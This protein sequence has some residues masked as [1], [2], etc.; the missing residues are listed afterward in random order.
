MNIRCRR[1]RKFQKEEACEP[2][3]Y[4]INNFTLFFEVRKLQSNIQKP[5]EE[6]IKSF[7]KSYLFYN[8]W[9]PFTSTNTT[10]TKIL[11]TAPRFLHQ[12]IICYGK[13]KYNHNPISINNAGTQIKSKLLPKM[14]ASTTNI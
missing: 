7:Q 1:M 13:E 11:P 2:K 9:S 8:K 12:R 4:S 10:P 14:L 6:Q 3:I 5:Y